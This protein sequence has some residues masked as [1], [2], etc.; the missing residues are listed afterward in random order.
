MNYE[1]IKQQAIKESINDSKIKRLSNIHIHKDY[2][3][4]IGFQMLSD[5][6]FRIFKKFNNIANPREHRFSEILKNYICR[7][8]REYAFSQFPWGNKKNRE[9]GTNQPHLII[10]GD[11]WT[12]EPFQY[13]G[14]Y[15][16]YTGSYRHSDYA[17][18]FHRNKPRFMYRIHG[19][20]KPVEIDLSLMLDYHVDYVD[21]QREI[22]YIFFGKYRD[23]KATRANYLHFH[24]LPVTWNEKEL[25][26]SYYNY[27]YHISPRELWVLD[28]HS[29]SLKILRSFNLRKK[30]TLQRQKEAERLELMYDHA[31]EVYVTISDSE[32]AG[33]CEVQTRKFAKQFQEKNQALEDVQLRGDLLLMHRDDAF[34]RRAVIQALKRNHIL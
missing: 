24:G 17:V 19:M 25:A 26:F 28:T 30:E 20:K 3:Y 15:K 2:R 11:L 10:S 8:I 7:T 1:E 9:E 23:E 16:G 18:I 6:E 5:I 4:D 29:L 32:K 33:N 31:H 27:I 13:K 22:Q 34:T 21:L 14:K 12:E